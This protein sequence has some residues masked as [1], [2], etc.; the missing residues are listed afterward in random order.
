MKKKWFMKNQKKKDKKED[1]RDVE[2]AI[3]KIGES[4]GPF[5]EICGIEIEREPSFPVRVTLQYYKA[6]SNGVI[7]EKV[8]KDINDQLKES[9][10]YGENFGSLVVDGKTNRPT[11]MKKQKKKN[12]SRR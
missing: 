11:E 9:Q 10:N 4:E 7:N 6:T 3:I 12:Q 5:D 1:E 2:D 8:M